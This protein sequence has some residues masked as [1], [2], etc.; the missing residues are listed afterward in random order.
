MAA[1]T[2]GLFMR[3]YPVDSRSTGGTRIASVCAEDFG[4]RVTVPGGAVICDVGRQPF[5]RMS[6]VSFRV[7]VSRVCIRAQEVSLKPHMGTE[8]R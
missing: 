2:F 1:A 5:R 3:Q 6:V 8:Q 7:T 4:Y